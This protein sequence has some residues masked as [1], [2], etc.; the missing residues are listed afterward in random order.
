MNAARLRKVASPV[1]QRHRDRE[2]NCDDLRHTCERPQ[3][4]VCA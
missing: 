1:H 2:A 4:A 3:L